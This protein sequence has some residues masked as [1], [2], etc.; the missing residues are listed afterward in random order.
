MTPEQPHIQYLEE[1]IKKISERIE[2]RSRQIE[3][4][5][6]Q[7]ETEKKALKE[8]EKGLKKMKEKEG[9]LAG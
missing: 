2:D 7:N 9:K 8:F 5:S 1:E 3:L 4:L 6:I